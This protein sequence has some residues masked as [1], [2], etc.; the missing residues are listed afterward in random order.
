MDDKI[1]V[2]LWPEEISIEFD[3][4]LKQEGD[5]FYK[6]CKDVI[7]PPIEGDFEEVLSKIREVASEYDELRIGVYGSWLGVKN[8]NGEQQDYVLSFPKVDYNKYHCAT[9][10]AEYLKQE[11]N[12]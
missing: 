12:K 4:I 7:R 11:E 8:Q 5:R 10:Y 2:R 9:L 6:H 3:F 1:N